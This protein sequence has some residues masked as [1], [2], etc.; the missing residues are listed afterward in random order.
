MAMTCRLSSGFGVV[1]SET[2][3]HYLIDTGPVVTV[4]LRAESSVN[5]Q[6]DADAGDANDVKSRMSTVPVV[7]ACAVDAPV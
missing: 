3:T 1:I 5:E 4:G 7:A 2:V 6:N